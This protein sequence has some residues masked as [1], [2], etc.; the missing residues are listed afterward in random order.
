MTTWV[1]LYWFII[2]CKQILSSCWVFNRSRYCILTRFFDLRIRAQCMYTRG[3]IPSYWRIIITYEP[4]LRDELHRRWTLR[5]FP[6]HIIRYYLYDS[7]RPRRE[8]TW[9]HNI[10]NYRRGSGGVKSSPASSDSKSLTP[11]P[12]TWVSYVIAEDH[13]VENLRKRI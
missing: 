13:L 10:S 8:G 4:K 11:D 3:C 5:R 2:F 12:C 7:Q 9:S 1:L 6:Q